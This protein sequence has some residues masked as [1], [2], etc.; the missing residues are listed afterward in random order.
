MIGCTANVSSDDSEPKIPYFDKIVHFG[1]FG[2]LAM[3]ATIEKK[4]A[5]IATLLVCAAYGV[6]IELI[7]Y[8]LPWRSFEVLDMV[9]D[10]LGAGAGI[11]AANIL[12]KKI[13]SK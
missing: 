12:M 8:F 9:F 6:A 10:T 3:L 5:S 11:I 7:Q 2:L 13:I 1:I 4:T